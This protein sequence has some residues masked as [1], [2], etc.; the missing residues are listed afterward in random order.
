MASGTGSG[1][2]GLPPSNVVKRLIV[3]TELRVA[4]S[5][6]LEEGRELLGDLE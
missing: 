6:R 1:D 2:L 4:F 5:L 3:A